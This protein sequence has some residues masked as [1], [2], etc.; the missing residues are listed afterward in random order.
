M[1]YSDVIEEILRR[2]DESNIGVSENRAKT[3]FRT[4]IVGL[5]RKEEYKKEDILKMRQLFTVASTG[6]AISFDTITNKAVTGYSLLLIN[7]GYFAVS[8]GSMML[9]KASETEI[10]RLSLNGS[11]NPVA[12]NAKFYVLGDKVYFTPT[13]FSSADVTFDAIVMPPAVDAVGGWV[14]A[15]DML[16]WFNGGFLE[17][18]IQ[19]AVGL[20]K[21]ELGNE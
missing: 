15:T 19:F 7:D 13:S 3:Y 2:S 18:S 9:S 10:R 4:A 14:D 6:A 1:D 11:L 21:G 20:L 17:D 12:A 8:T 5:I 16:E